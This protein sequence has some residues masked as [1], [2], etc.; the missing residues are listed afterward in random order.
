MLTG[1]VPDL[2]PLL[3]A[4]ASPRR[5][6]LLAGL[7]LEFAI[8]SA[9]LDERALPGETPAALVARLAASKA[10]ALEHPDALVI[11]ADTV[12]VLGDSVL[13]KPQDE[14]ENRDFL[15]RLAGREHEV[16]TG[17][18]LLYRGR[19][20]GAVRRTVVRFRD[21]GEDE[22]M[23]Y[24][25]SGEGLDKAGGYAIQGR[26]GAL[27]KHLEGCYF[28][29]VGLSLATVVELAARLGVRLV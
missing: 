15:R 3:L 19:L 7:G 9:D 16:L 8:A 5:R 20:E 1:P 25:A 11:A 29:V 17:H 4:S 26:G 14:A 2:P 13:G 27:V 21:L 23:R 28:N 10:R 12:V 18:A 22:I 24:V 6:E